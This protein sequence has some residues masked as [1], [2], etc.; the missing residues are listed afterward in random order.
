MQFH[1]SA[2]RR[3]RSTTGFRRAPD[4]GCIPGMLVRAVLRLLEQKEALNA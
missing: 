4:P 3:R 2:E 1:G